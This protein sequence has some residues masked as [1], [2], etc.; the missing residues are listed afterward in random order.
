MNISI[1]DKIYKVVETLPHHGCGYP[2]KIVETESG[3]KVAVKRG[4]EWQF[5]STEDRLGFNQRE[6]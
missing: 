2:A 4:G 6:D 1:D 3:E 5:W